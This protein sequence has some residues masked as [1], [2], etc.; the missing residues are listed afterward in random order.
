[1]TATAN[2]MIATANPMTPFQAMRSIYD[3]WWRDNP[4]WER[5]WHARRNA[6][7]IEMVI[8]ELGTDITIVDLG[9]GWGTFAAGCSFV[10]MRAVLV[11]DFRNP[12]HNTDYREALRSSYDISIVSRDII[13]DGIDF[14]QGTIDCFTCFHSMEHWHHSP[15]R[16]FHQVI[17]ALRPG[18]LFF[19]GL[20]NCVNLRKRITVPLGHGKW[21]SM[22]DW[23]EEPV[24]RGHVRE[25]DIDDLRYLARDLGLVNARTFGRNY[26]AHLSPSRLIRL[27]TDIADYPLRFFPSLCGDIYLLGRKPG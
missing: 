4:E 11:D 20:P 22:Q 19:V 23:Y 16:L 24:F 3:Q 17:E 25:A 6:D 2:H 18:G 5:Y 12:D 21:N 8:H 27:C 10:G 1:M 14:P 13:S 15:K 9:G 7:Q 26:I